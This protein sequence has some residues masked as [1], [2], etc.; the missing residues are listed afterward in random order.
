M[1]RALFT[2]GFQVTP[3]D[4]RSNLAMGVG[5]LLGVTVATQQALAEKAS[6]SVSWT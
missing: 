4:I 3:K 2:Q 6:V 1:F 5:L